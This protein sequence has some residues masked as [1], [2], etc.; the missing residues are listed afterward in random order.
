M[1]EELEFELKKFLTYQR[2]R[3]VKNTTEGLNPFNRNETD[4]KKWDDLI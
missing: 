2:M 4:S 3:K 1:T